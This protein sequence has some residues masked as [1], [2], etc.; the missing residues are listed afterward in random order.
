MLIA[1]IHFEPTAFTL[2]N[3]TNQPGENGKRC[4]W[5]P[6]RH[7]SSKP[8]LSSPLLTPA[9]FKQILIL[10]SFQ[11]LKQTKLKPNTH[12]HTGP[13]M[14]CFM[15]ILG[16]VCAFPHFGCSLKP[17]VAG[18]TCR[19]QGI[20]PSDSFFFSVSQTPVLSY[21][22]NCSWSFILFLVPQNSPSPGTFQCSPLLPSQASFFPLK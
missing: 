14:N 3:N 2:E 8:A 20:Q 13:P 7:Q 21:Q 6:T 10:W 22:K 17:A 9:S 12:R 19:E 11:Y 1:F 16:Q 5:Q 15:K 4:T 18:C